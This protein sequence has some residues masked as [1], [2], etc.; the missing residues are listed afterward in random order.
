M[1][2]KSI[3]AEEINNILSRLYN[4]I[5]DNNIDLLRAFAQR[6]EQKEIDFD[7]QNLSNLFL[8]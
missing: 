2:G 8:T 5:K 1:H 4:Y 3:L 6:N 7:N